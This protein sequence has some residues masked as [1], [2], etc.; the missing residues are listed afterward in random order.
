MD[1]SQSQ[2]RSGSDELVRKG[3]MH[4]FAMG[5]PVC[6]QA[7]QKQSNEAFYRYVMMHTDGSGMDDSLRTG[8]TNGGAKYN[9]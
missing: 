5:W 1:L 2:S 3:E 9:S 6:G 4:T 8:T 7:V